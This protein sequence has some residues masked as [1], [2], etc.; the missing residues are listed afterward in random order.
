MVRVLFVCLGNICRSPTAEGVFRR[1]VQER[2]LSARILVDSAGTS[3]WH[4]GAPPDPRTLRHAKKRGF[5]LSD[6]RARRVR[7]DDFARFDH[8]LAMDDANLAALRAVCPPA[9]AGKLRLFLACAPDV[10]CREVPDPYEGGEDG[11][12][13]VL[14]LCETAARALLEEI[15][16]AGV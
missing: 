13:H 10:G 2:G 3:G 6:L 11:F 7:E 15:V 8:V 4:E 14:D 5:D 1:L 16:A 12:E 9:Y